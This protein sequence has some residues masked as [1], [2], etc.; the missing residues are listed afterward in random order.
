M[1][2]KGFEREEM[3]KEVRIGMT[4]S[5]WASRVCV[6]FRAGIIPDLPIGESCLYKVEGRLLEVA[7]IK[8]L[9]WVLK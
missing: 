9:W 3:K 2:L 8:K 6:R 7:D 5:L 1:K 4:R